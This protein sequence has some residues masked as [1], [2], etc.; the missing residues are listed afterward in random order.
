MTGITIRPVAGKADMDAFIQAAW[1]VQAG[2]PSWVPP[3]RGDVRGLLSLRHPFWKHAERE[4]FLACRGEAV[5]GRIA[6]IRDDA[7]I[8]RHGEQAGAFGFF[9][10]LRDI[11]AARALF[12]AA[13]GWCRE[14][15]LTRMRGPLSPSTNYEMGVLVEGFDS[16]PMIM[17]PHNPPWYPELIE[18]CGLA[19]EKDVFAYRF[20]R[21]HRPPEAARQRAEAMRGDPDIAI[22]PLKRGTLRREADLLCAIFNEVW[23]NNWGFVPMEPEEVRHTAR[24]VDFILGE[25]LPFVMTF[26]GE[27]AALFMF[28]PDVNP[29]LKRLNGAI[30]LRGVL[31]YLLHRGEMRSTRLLLFGVRPKFRRRG[32][33]YALL[34]H[35]QT[36][37]FDNPRYDSH[38]IGWVL[39]DNA[40]MN[41]RMESFGGRRAKRC[42]IY[43]LDL[44]A[45]GGAPCAS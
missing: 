7:F 43:A 34:D 21:G 19:K 15:G 40:A 39:E 26:R 24:D 44:P 6:A 11:E 25:P 31:Q 1:T 35:M 13:A 2:D 12:C 20:E 18:A 38:E 27:P 36:H 9:E 28:L 3:L 37:L 29:L 41:A 33:S 17:M 10:C 4:L 42:R 5:V 22:R 23:Q 32:L 45:P 30:G 14:R 8:A 16:P